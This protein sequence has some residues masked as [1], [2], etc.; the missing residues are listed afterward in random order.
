MKTMLIGN[1]D[2][3]LE[4]MQMRLRSRGL[5]V[6]RRREIVSPAPAPAVPALA[7]FQPI[8]LAAVGAK[9]G[10]PAVDAVRA[11]RQVPGGDAPVVLVVVDERLDSDGLEKLIDAGASDFI[12]WP[13]DS[14]VVPARLAALE[15]R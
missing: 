13:R 5:V 8:V 1:D 10:T 7:D 3:A 11:L 2:S 9:G 6:V 12:V 14:E 15:E 4:G